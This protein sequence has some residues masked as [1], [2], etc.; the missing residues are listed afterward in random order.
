VVEHLGT[1]EEDVT[2]DRVHEESGHD[3]IKEREMLKKYVKGL[4]KTGL[5]IFGRRIQGVW[6]N[7][8]PFID[9]KTSTAVEKLGLLGNAEELNELMENHWEKLEVEDIESKDLEEKKRKSF[10]KMF[11]NRCAR[12]SGGSYRIYK[13]RDSLTFLVDCKVVYSTYPNRFEIPHLLG[14]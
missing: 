12:R 9:G 1:R 3:A 4:G 7:F 8:H 6:P 5:D 13:G 11:G 2:L 14:F 10:L